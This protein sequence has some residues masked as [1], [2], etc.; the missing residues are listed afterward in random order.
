MKN[1]INAVKLIGILGAGLG[2][3]A[4]LVSNYATSKEQEAMIE[5]KINEAI[6]KKEN[7]EA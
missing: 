3:V 2:F 1:K 7:E 6:S 5:E 4:T